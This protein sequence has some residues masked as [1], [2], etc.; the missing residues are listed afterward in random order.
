MGVIPDGSVPR[1]FPQST[2]A[3]FVPDPPSRW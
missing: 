1:P 2:S 3:G